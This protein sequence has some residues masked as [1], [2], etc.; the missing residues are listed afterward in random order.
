MDVSN[1]DKMAVI[2]GIV[3]STLFFLVLLAQVIATCYT[4]RAANAARSAADEARRANNIA[5]QETVIRHQPSLAIHMPDLPPPDNQADP[6]ILSV[7]IK[8][9]GEWPANEID[10]FLE[11]NR[12]L[13]TAVA[14]NNKK[15]RLSRNAIYGGDTFRNIL[16]MSQA[17]WRGMVNSE[18]PMFVA[19]C[20]TYNDPQTAKR[21]RVEASYRMEGSILQPVKVGVPE[22]LSDPSFQEDHSEEAQR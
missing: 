3:T 17:D 2:V 6:V 9:H 1:W 14:L 12:D 11:A 10:I 4:R 16:P 13:D 21:W 19:G 18:F 15:I 20:V 7:P 22:L 5:E 8:N